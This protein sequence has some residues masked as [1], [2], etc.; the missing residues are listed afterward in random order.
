MTIAS[1][2]KDLSKRVAE[3][4]K[5]VLDQLRDPDP[6]M[7][8]V[9]SNRVADN[10]RPLFAIA[11]LAGDDWPVKARKIAIQLS[12]DGGVSEEEA[13]LAAIAEA[14]GR[15]SSDRFS[16]D[17]LCEL[18]K[19]GSDDRFANIV[20]TRLAKLLKPFGIRPKSVRIGPRALKGYM[21][22]SFEDALNRY[23]PSIPVTAATPEQSNEA[24]GLSNGRPATDRQRDATD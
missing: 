16:S 24:N 13:L 7:P 19:A 12:G 5:A 6:A 1:S 18:L 17:Q 2:S 15:D 21:R 9:L 14:L 4:A 23:V 3:W 20:P 10:W 22:S 11:D 8:E